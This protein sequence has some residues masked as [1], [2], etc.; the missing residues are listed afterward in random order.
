[1]KTI[2][3]G[4]LV[5]LLKGGDEHAFS[6][7]YDTLWE[8]LFSFVVRA[9]KDTD[10]AM[11]I[12]QETFI[13]IWQQRNALESVQSVRSYVFSIARYKA[14]RYIRLNIQKRDYL[15]SLW[16]FFDT[17]T[18]SPEELLTADE[19][20]HAIDKQVAKLPPKMREVFLLSRDEHLS[21]KEI[22]ARLNISDKTVKKQINNS[23]K[24]LRLKLDKGH[25][26]SLLLALFLGGN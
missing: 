3:D 8:P 5:Q 16:Q 14:L 12:V 26:S 21:Y 4:V 23:L 6:S 25:L 24:M 15:T 19:L 18:E 17:Y 22:A 2:E 1:M 13:S 11:D 20:Q 7:F 9:V 10:D